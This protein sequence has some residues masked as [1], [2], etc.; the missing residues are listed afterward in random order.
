VNEEA[1]SALEGRDEEFRA[2]YR[3]YAAARY[4]MI[5]G[6][7]N[8]DRDAALQALESAVLAAQDEMPYELK[9]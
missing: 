5:G 1:E 7:W 9:G 6:G 3:V 4:L 8:D 2:L